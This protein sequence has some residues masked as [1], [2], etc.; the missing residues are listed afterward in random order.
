[1]VQDRPPRSA[2]RVR[3]IGESPR[4]LR[5]QVSDFELLAVRAWL[6]GS[7][8][9]GPVKD[10][11]AFSETC[12]QPDLRGMIHLRNLHEPVKSSHFLAGFSVGG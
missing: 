11:L 1:V 4:V 7:R 9:G 2:H 8:P 6:M 10:D 3:W 5:S 12:R